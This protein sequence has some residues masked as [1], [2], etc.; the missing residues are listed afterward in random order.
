MPPA[1][2]RRLQ[3]LDRIVA[4]LQTITAGDDY[5]FTPGEVVRR[6][7]HWSEAKVF[8]TYMV[9]AASGGKVEL[10]GA[11]DLYDEDV[12]VSVKGIVR[13][14]EDTVSLIEKALRDVRRAINEDA[15]SGAAGSLGVLAVETRIEE[16]PETDDGYLSIEGFG[17]F[18]QR[19]RVR[20]AG[21]YGEL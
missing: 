14:P 19:I 1:N 20:I 18:D 6:F 16:G 21:D 8:P 12:M 17:F 15:K 7:V 3:V 10:S 9:F 2:P 4:V 11:P 5:F 13:H